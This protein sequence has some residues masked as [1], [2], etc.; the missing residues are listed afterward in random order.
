MLNS[1]LIS[2]VKPLRL[3]ARLIVEGFLTGLHKSPY[4]GFSV[5]FKDHRSYNK[6]DEIRWID[7][8]VYAR[9]DRFY[10][11]RF[12][13]ETNL[14]AY[15][16]LD[17]SASMGFVKEKFEYAV[18][19]ASAISYLL[20][21]QRD[22]FGLAVFNE[23]IET[24]VPPR[25][26][27]V[28]LSHVMSILDGLKTHGQTDLSSFRVLAERLK[29]RGLVVFISDMMKEPEEIITGLRMFRYRKHEV[30]AFHILSPEETKISGR[31]RVF[32]DMETGER[33]PFD[34]VN[35]QSEYQERL[36]SHIEHIKKELR[37]SNIDYEFFLTSEPIEL[38]LYRFFKKREKLR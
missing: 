22:A 30:I 32:E 25:T 12:E 4:H 11:R 5:E 33:V 17:N 26:S 31:A 1:E 13:D 3:R 7:W 6:G 20:F 8:K 23:K 37:K 16:L 36:N 10:V 19:L 35:L 2:K 38:A 21:L 29:K 14:M 27:R 15:I 9:T 28:N 24:L 18:N 34:P